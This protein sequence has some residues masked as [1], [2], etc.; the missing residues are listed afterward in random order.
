MI[1]HLALDLPVQY[2]SIVFLLKGG[3]KYYSKK[4]MVCGAME[5]WPPDSRAQVEKVIRFWH[6]FLRCCTNVTPM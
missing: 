2:R 4:K 6:D 1:E 5:K 3:I